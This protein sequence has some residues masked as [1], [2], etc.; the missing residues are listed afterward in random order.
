MPRKV[1]LH[2]RQRRRC[3]LSNRY[4]RPLFLIIALI[5]F[6]I[7]IVDAKLLDVNWTDV[8]LLSWVI[9]QLVEKV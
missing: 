6:V 1:Q 5:A 7:A 8:G 2:L 3:Q 4:G 9:S